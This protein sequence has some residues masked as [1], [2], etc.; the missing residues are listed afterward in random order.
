MSTKVSCRKYGNRKCRLSQIAAGGKMMIFPRAH[1][2]SWRRQVKSHMEQ[3]LFRQADKWKSIFLK[4]HP[5][6]AQ[7]SASHISWLRVGC[8]IFKSIQ[9][10]I[11]FS[12]VYRPIAVAVTLAATIIFITK[13]AYLKFYSYEAKKLPTQTD[14]G[15]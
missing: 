8:Y 14:R 2:I 4:R 1:I 11:L 9:S 13:N 15:K 7:R 12:I 5:T 10:C 6:Q 3:I